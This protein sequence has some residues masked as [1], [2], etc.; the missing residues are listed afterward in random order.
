MVKMYTT[1]EFFLPPF[2]HERAGD[3]LLVSGISKVK[4]VNDVIL[5]SSYVTLSIFLTITF[6]FWIKEKIILFCI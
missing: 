3:I 5:S 1:P 6:A 2:I 4:Y